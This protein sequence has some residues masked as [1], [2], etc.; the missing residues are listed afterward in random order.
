MKD[1]RQQELVC[2]TQY[3]YF[4]SLLY[5]KSVW[6]IANNFSMYVYYAWLSMHNNYYRLSPLIK[7]I[8]KIETKKAFFRVSSNR[9]ILRIIQSVT[10]CLSPLGFIKNIFDILRFYYL[11]LKHSCRV[12]YKI[13]NSRQ[14]LDIKQIKLIDKQFENIPITTLFRKKVTQNGFI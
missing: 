7:T 8:S 14:L 3:V 1:D 6:F 2:S 4:K 5:H 10:Y 13:S 9:E 11:R 12:G